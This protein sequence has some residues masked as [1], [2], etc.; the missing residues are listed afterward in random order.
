MSVGTHRLSGW[1]L[2]MGAGLFVLASLP[3]LVAASNGPTAD[4]IQL[5]TL[6]IGALL[7]I[8]GLPASYRKQARQVGWAG[9]IGFIALFLTTILLGIVENVVFLVSDARTGADSAQPSPLFLVAALL[10]GLLALIGGLLYGIVTIRAR[11]FPAAIGWLLIVAGVLSLTLFL[12]PETLNR[13]GGSAS[14]IALFLAF[15]WM[16]Y[17]LAFPATQDVISSAA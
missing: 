16:G 3:S 8:V 1:L 11:V 9:R 12:A 15:G 2:L 14:E 7:V 6:I 17:R 10:G 4:T 5:C 13:I